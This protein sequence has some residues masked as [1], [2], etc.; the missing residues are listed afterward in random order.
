MIRHRKGGIGC[1]PLAFLPLGQL[2][3]R[4][5]LNRCP[6]SHTLYLG[7][8][9]RPTGRP[10][11]R[12]RT[13]HSLYASDKRNGPPLPSS[14]SHSTNP[15]S[16]R[17]FRR[18]TSPAPSKASRTSSTT[19]YALLPSMDEQDSTPRYRAVFVGLCPP[20]PS[21]CCPRCSPTPGRTRS[22]SP[23]ARPGTSP[24]QV[25]GRRTPGQRTP[26]RCLR[27]A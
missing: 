5:S 6:Y 12:K 22:P 2:S 18:K 4:S 26:G 24:A 10:D 15:K 19:M 11:G 23:T 25:R 1:H 3:H 8:S 14:R 27:D 7:A 16:S 17:P 21:C 20:G 9:S 13:M